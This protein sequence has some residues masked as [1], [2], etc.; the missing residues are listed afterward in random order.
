MALTV[1]RM[2]VLAE[3][4]IEVVARIAAGVK[5]DWNYVAVI[6]GTSLL[7]IVNEAITAVA[8]DI[9]VRKDDIRYCRLCGKGP[10]TKKGMYLHLIR[11]HRYE[12]KVL[13]NEELERRVGML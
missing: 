13:I 2:D 8:E 9:I 4:L 3:K 6:A 10:F 11:V 12:L 5:V 1:T 7:N